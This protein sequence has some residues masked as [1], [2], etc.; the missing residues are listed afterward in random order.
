MAATTAMV[1]GCGGMRAGQIVA[2]RSSVPAAGSPSTPTPT[3]TPPPP[4]AIDCA[5]TPCVALTFDDGPGEHTGRLLD[6]LRREGARATFFLLGQNVAPHRDLVRRMALEGH[7][8]ANHSWSHPQL[9]GMSPDAVRSQV[10][11]T[12]E[13]V[14][15][16]S[17]MTPTLFRPPYGATDGKVARAVGMP[18]IMWSVDTLDWRDRS[19]A[20]VARIG[21]RE[22]GKG[23]I[24]L[25]HDI[26][27]TTVEA[28]PR[29]LSG[30][31]K[32]GFTLVTVSEM[33]HGKQLRPGHKYKNR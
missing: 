18:Q 33:F 5:R 28:V 1:A 22:P 8:V 2:A 7:E 32:R 13:A 4:R 3:P 9:T 23:G 27:R 17:G 25:L 16:A 11:R 6:D 10:R 20:R 12:N 21:V 30:L 19:A 31:K 24:V 14:R 29:M 26:H 15:E